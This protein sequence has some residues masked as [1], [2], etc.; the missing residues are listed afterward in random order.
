[1]ARVLLEGIYRVWVEVDADTQ[2]DAYEKARNV[3]IEEVVKN[4]IPISD[5]EDFQPVDFLT[6]DEFYEY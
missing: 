2:E 4:G 3:N 5:I 1:M 6:D